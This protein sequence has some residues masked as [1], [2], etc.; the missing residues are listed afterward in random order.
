MA[1]LLALV[2]YLAISIPVT[3]G[4]L[5]LIWLADRYEREPFGIVLMAA[6]W[7]TLPAVFLSCLLEFAVQTPLA[8]L[9]ATPQAIDPFMTIAVAPV[10]E[11]GVKAVA[12]FLMVALRR[13]EF[14]DVLDGMVYGAA[15]GVGFS[16]VEDLIYFVSATSTQGVG[17]GMLT[18]FLRNLGFLLNHSFFTALTGIGLGLAR[19]SHR[20]P[21]AAAGF[22]A[23]GFLAAV[24]L[25]AAHNALASLELPGLM[26]ALYL[27]LL[28]GIGLVVTV[29]LCWETEKRWIAT[30][31]DEEVAEG[32]IPAG[33]L[34]ALPYLR[35]QGLPKGKGKELRAALQQLAFARRQVKEGWSPESAAELEPLR[36]KVRH[37]C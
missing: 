3:A 24:G 22:P 19:Q 10:V 15:V 14:D 6:A 37:L 7:G 2:A 33:A 32:R 27:H 25:H 8:S 16:F 31:L 5:L 30:R 18:F 23:A 26:G 13:R 36:E 29:F 35:R 9:G 12:L 17:A 11:E 20:R 34:A 28:A 4:L 1:T 21:L